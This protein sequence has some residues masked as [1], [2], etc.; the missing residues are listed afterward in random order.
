MSNPLLSKETWDFADMAVAQDWELERGN[1]GALIW[2]DLGPELA[3]VVCENPEMLEVLV[4]LVNNP[5]AWVEIGTKDLYT[6]K[7]GV[8]RRTVTRAWAGT[9]T[10]TGAL[11]RTREG[12]W[13]VLRATVRGR[14]GMWTGGCVW[15]GEER[16]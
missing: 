14:S 3:R 1:G 6:A 8:G 11:T 16:G 4:V 13:A 5:G 7:A 10:G 2:T 9:G 15:T 12:T